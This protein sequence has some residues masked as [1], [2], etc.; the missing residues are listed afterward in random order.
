M[1][2]R[3]FHP[4]GHRQPPE[5]LQGCASC[6]RHPRQDRRGHALRHAGAGHPDPG[7]FAQ[8]RDDGV[9]GMG[10]FVS[11]VCNR[12]G[13]G[14]VAHENTPKCFCSRAKCPPE[15]LPSAFVF[16]YGFD[17][18]TTGKTD[19]N[20]VLVVFFLRPFMSVSFT[21]GKVYPLLG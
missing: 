12:R 18:R 7:T 3:A 20:I 10:V 15:R 2:S 16:F 9:L 5:D 17:D 19:G 4:L 21:S 14:R 8:A 1:L 6:D 11:V 13:A